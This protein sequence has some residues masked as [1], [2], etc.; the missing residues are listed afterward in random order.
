MKKVWQVIFVLCMMA[1]TLKAETTN[2][3]IAD[4]WV[5]S[6]YQKLTEAEKIGQLID[7]RIA[8]KLENI[9]ELLLRLVPMLKI[10][11]RKR[12]YFLKEQ[13]VAVE[14]HFI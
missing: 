10:Y 14:G 1:A 2:S 7:L 8:P 5:D 6:M 12:E 4:V 11:I 9:Q 13:I 3:F